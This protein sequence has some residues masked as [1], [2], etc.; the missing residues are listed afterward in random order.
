MRGSGAGAFSLCRSGRTSFDRVPREAQSVPNRR[1]LL[2][3]I[4]RSPSC[5]PV[6]SASRIH[7]QFS[8][9]RIHKSYIPIY[10]AL[11]RSLVRCLVS[12][13][14]LSSPPSSPVIYERSWCA[15]VPRNVRLRG[16]VREMSDKDR[17]S[18]IL[19]E[20]S[21]KSLLDQPSIFP[22]IGEY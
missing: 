4:T 16:A 11:A 1:A 10:T 14:L 21:L 5:V 20:N 8:R 3:V 2:A 12:P 9:A 7:P 15:C 13:P 17:S 6:H 19:V 18:P 22:L